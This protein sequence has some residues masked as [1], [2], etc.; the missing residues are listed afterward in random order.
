M[1]FFRCLSYDAL[2]RECHR[3]HDRGV[4]ESGREFSSLAVTARETPMVNE[5]S[6][7]TEV[8]TATAVAGDVQLVKPGPEGRSM[9]E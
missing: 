7:S 2:L 6:Q 5:S 8:P 3:G 1:P 9:R 4:F